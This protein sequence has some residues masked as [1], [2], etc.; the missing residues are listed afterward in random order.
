VISFLSGALT[1]AL[2]V[3]GM[4]FL[5]FWR[6]TS[7]RFFM[8]FGV[9]FLLLSLNQGLAH[10]IG[11]ADERVAYIYLLRVLAFLLILGAIVAKNLSKKS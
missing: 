4:F 5:R 9:A 8:A 6:R 7:D 11:L 10:W 2:L 1:L 3:A